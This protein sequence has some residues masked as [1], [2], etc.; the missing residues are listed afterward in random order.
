MSNSTNTRD[1]RHDRR[2][3]PLGAYIATAGAIVLLVS[4]YL[5]WF[6]TGAGDTE[7][8]SHNGYEGDGLIPMMGYLALGFA[9]A[10]LY[11]LKRADRRQHRGLSLASFAVGLASLIWCLAFMFNPIGTVQYGENIDVMW[12]AYIAALGALLWTLGSFLLAKEPEGDFEDVHRTT[13][14]RPVAAHTE[15]HRVDT[16]ATHTTGTNVH[17]HDAHRT[18]G[19]MGTQGSHEVPGADDRN[20]RPGSAF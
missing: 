8:E 15:T 19:T 18:T 13:A 4:V 2:A 16:G 1:D 14:T 6:A 20:R 17:E 9:I 5:D 11:A 10:L 7:G 3:N 12:G